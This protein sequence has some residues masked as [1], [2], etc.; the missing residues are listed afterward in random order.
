MISGWPLYVP[1]DAP[2]DIFSRMVGERTAKARLKCEF[3]LVVRIDE[4]ATTN[5]RT[6]GG[7][8]LVI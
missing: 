8:E 6:S 1:V 7:T 3:P 5:F 2:I 4:P